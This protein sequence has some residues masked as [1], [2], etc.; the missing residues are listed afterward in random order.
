LNADK[1]LDYNSIFGGGAGSGG[2]SEISIVPGVQAK[3]GLFFSKGAFEEYARSIEVGVMA[4]FFI[5][6]IPIMVETDAISAKPYFLNFYVTI[7][8]GKRTN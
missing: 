1:F 8:F 2:L 6:K 3:L 5:R 7:E 4:D